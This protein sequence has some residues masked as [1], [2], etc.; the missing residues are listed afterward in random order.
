M[1]PESLAALSSAIIGGMGK[2]RFRKT[3]IRAWRKHRTLSLVKL[4][5]RI[6]MTP[7]N[8]SKIER[9]EQPYTQPVLEALAEALNVTAA[10]LIMRPPGSIAPLRAELESLAPDDQARA[11]AI[12]KALKTQAA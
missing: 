2:K 6:D 5:S 3:Q 7:S 1:I 11:L 12:I 4:A 10:D 8:L 9:G